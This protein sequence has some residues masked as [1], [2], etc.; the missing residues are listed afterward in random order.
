MSEWLDRV[1]KAD[2]HVH[3]IASKDSLSKGE[4]LVARAKKLGL[5]KLILT[6]HNTISG[7]LELQKAY[8]DF[9]IVGEEILTTSG[10]ILAIFVKEELPKGI[11]PVEAFKRL[12]D[13]G[14]FIHFLIPMLPRVM[15]GLR[16]RWKNIFRIWM[17]LKSRM[18]G[19]CRR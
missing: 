3:S 8:P 5:G 14:A 2:F 19:I 10:E 4:D 7:A 12:K 18:P 16:R 13:Q 9:V 15:A 17:Q 1:I 6:D 11:K